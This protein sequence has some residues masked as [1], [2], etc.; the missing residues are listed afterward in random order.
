VTAPASA[1]GPFYKGKRVTLVINFAA[2]GPSDLEG[3]LLARHIVKHID[4]NPQIVIQNKDGAGGLVG[5][6]FLGELGT[7]DGLMFGYFTGAAWKYL[8]EPENH[9]VDFRAFE[10]IGFQPGN[11]VYYMRADT[12]PG[13]KLPADLLKAQG[14]VIG[15]LAV[16]SSKDLLMRTSL[17]MLGVPY[18][19][20]TGY[21]SSVNARLAVQRGEIHMHSESTPAFLGVVEPTMVKTGV[22]VA[23]Y[24]D[25]AYNGQTFGV[26]KGMENSAI[27]PFHELY[28]SLKGTLPSGRLW[29]AYSTNLKVDSAMLRTVVLPPGVPQ[30]AVDA[31]RVALA[32]L[33][34]DK[35]YADDAMKSIQFVPHYETG[36]DINER[37]RRAM[38]VPPE[39]RAFVLE[40]MKAGAR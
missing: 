4:G 25:P 12:P 17:D 10:F 15:G 22:A 20:I 7:R 34:A 6:N 1:Q 40:Y 31:L 13:M 3:R 29:D 11:A 5:T 28:R 24:Y 27:P 18:K 23:P 2:G 26:P 32:R 16:E 37:V 35:D 9:R 21:R 19:Y 33:N 30:A 8:V 39:I 38:A 36:A 14:L